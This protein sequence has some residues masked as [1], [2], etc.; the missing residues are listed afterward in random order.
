M[1]NLPT[2]SLDPTLDNNGH[3]FY[4]PAVESTPLQLHTI[5]TI[6]ALLE[7]APEWQALSAALPLQSPFITP[8]WNIL[9]WQHLHASRLLIHDR[10][11]VFVLRDEQG[12]LRAVAPMMTSIRPGLGGYGIKDLQFFGADPNITEIRGM[13]CQQEH[14]DAALVCLQTH[15]LKQQHRWDWIEWQGL[16]LAQMRQLSSPGV[17]SP[18][19]RVICYLPLPDQWR[20]LKAGLSRNM[21]QAIRKC[22]NTLKQAKHEAQLEVLDQRDQP[23]QFA[24]ALATFFQ[25]HRLR[26][27]ADE[28]VMHTDVF[29][30]GKNHRFLAAYLQAA[31]QTDQVKIFQLSIDGKVVASRIGIGLGSDKQRQL[32][33]YYSGYDT[34][35]GAFSVMTTLVILSLQWAIAQAYLGVNLSTGLDYAKQRW[36]PQEL[37]QHNAIQLAPR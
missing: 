1:A 18:K 5:T 7:L 19:A 26:A 13:I 25:L 3:D 27:K 11:N 2:M 23:A 36:Q 21:K 33:L 15:L 37:I 20:S 35:W 8:A 24:Q 30:S 14:A 28:G 17:A 10:L 22:F 31:A 32:Y 9:W 34:A 29:R 12:Q 16:N 4:L 6:A